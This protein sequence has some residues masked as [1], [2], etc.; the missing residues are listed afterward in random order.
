[1]GIGQPG[2]EREERHLN[3]EGEGEGAEEPELRLGI[4]GSRGPQPL[5]HQRQVEGAGVL[6]Q[7]ED[8]KE[9]QQAA[10]HRVDEE[11][12]GCV[13][14]PLAAPD[15]DDQVHRNQHCLV[16]EVEEDDV[17]GYECP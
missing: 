9:H 6:P 1:M 2:V 7:V 5:Q 17:E 15:S 3:G 4:E 13:D 10:D 16:V 14:P 12:E 11:L 8:R